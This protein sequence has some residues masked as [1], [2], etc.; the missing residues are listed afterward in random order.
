MP[1]PLTLVWA[2]IGVI[3]TALG[4][5]W[6]WTL[7]IPTLETYRFSLQLGGVFLTACL[8]GSLAGFY[9]QVGYVALGLSGI[10]IFSYG[11]GWDYV[12]QPAFGYLLGFIPG[13]WVC[14]WF[15]C[16]PLGL[17]VRRRR[18]P[19]LWAGCLLGLAVI[20]GVGWVGLLLRWGWDGW[21]YGWRYSLY[22]LPGQLL[23]IGLVVVVTFCY[24]RL[25]FHETSPGAK[26]LASRRPANLRSLGRE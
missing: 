6:Q 2:A 12:Q 24:R 10:P 21:D 22:P 15:A 4:T 13:A 17:G 8:G 14:G 26:R 9:A 20:H 3:L 18:R 7:P 1:T 16:P 25:T 19:R 23:V 5:L 11:G